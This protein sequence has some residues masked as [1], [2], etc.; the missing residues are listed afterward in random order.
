M[1][2][3]PCDN[4]FRNLIPMTMKHEVLR[5]I[6]IANGTLH[7][8]NRMNNDVLSVSSTAHQPAA[9]DTE[10]MLNPSDI[11]RHERYIDALSAKHYAPKVAEARP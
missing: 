3:D 2:D 5:H 4:L 1:Y 10:K 9:K 11:Q 6:M 8:S 7:L